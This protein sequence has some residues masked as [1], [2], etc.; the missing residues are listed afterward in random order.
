M[1]KPRV[2]IIYHYVAHYRKSIFDTLC[3]NC[4]IDYFIAADE[5]SNISS[6]P[7]L[8]STKESCG[9]AISERWLKI[10]NLWI[11]KDI[12]WQKGVISIALS[13]KFDCLILLGNMYFLSTWVATILARA[14]GK[15]VIY[16]THGIRR[17]E[18]GL[19]GALR[20]LFYKMADDLLLYG[21]RAKILLSNGGISAEKMHVIYNSLE[22]CMQNI[23]FESI[24][25]NDKN[26]KRKL[27]G[28]TPDEKVIIA[29]GRITRDKK[30]SILIDA[31]EILIKKMSIDCKLIVIGD[32]PESM[33]L[34][35]KILLKELNDK[36]I[37]YGA[38]YEEN[39]IALLISLSNVCVVPGD[40]GLSAIH[41][42]TYG[43]PVIT[44][45][46]FDSHK[47]E[48]E[49][50]SEGLNGAFYQHGNTEDLCQKIATWIQKERTQTLRSCRRVILQFYNPKYQIEKINRVILRGN[51]F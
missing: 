27:L 7:I 21:N 31:L 8:N 42:L 37:M 26:E 34:K 10:R 5:S 23:I 43:T 35:R 28:L 39:E 40:I 29:I 12:V 19:K 47:P 2:A 49:A 9:S 4:E 46:N 18:Y 16:W 6:L 15:K 17:K 44:H 25:K 45:N 32:G 50:I 22:F 30:F 3:T 36:V 14:K 1:K 11:T 41:S 48:F 51:S 24:N 33:T 38:C 20:K 13:R